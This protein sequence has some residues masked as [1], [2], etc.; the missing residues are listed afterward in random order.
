[1][2]VTREDRFDSQPLVDPEAQLL[3]VADLRLDNREA[4]AATLGLSPSSLT[5]LPDSALLM[6]AHRRWGENCAEHLIGDFAFA[7]WDGRARRLLLCRD[8]MGQR[9]LFYHQG[10]ALPG[11]RHRR[12]KAAL[13]ALAEVPRVLSHE[14]GLA[15]RAL[16][17]RR[18]RPAGATLFVGIEALPGGTT[19]SIEASGAARSRRYWTPHAA[20]AHL[21]RDEAYYRRGVPFQVLAEAGGLPAAA[22]DPAGGA[23]APAAASTAPQIAGLAA[24]A[25]EGPQASVALNVHIGR[26]RQ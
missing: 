12:S 10:D 13:E 7:L 9:H 21:G 25:L 6:A 4:L 26:G 3:L 24:P 5:E 17:E 22:G 20:E 2:Q 8:H 18:Y 15:R 14:I 1:M 23:D 16:V 19:M 11:L